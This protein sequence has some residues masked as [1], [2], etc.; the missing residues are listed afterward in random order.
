MSTKNIFVP[1]DVPEKSIDTFVKNYSALTHGTNNMLLFSADQKIEHLHKDFIGPDVDPADSYPTH[2]FDIASQADIGGMATQ[3]GLIARY[4]KQYKNINYVV[5]LNAKTNIIPTEYADPLSKELWTIQQVVQF[6]EQTK[7]PI[8]GIGYTVYLGS[9]F[10]AEM[11]TQAAQAVYEA[12]QHGLVTILWMYP[13]GECLEGYERQGLIIAGAAGVANAL[14]SD[15][16]KIN[17]PEPVDEE[18]EATSNQWL[19]IAGQAAGNTRLL[20]SGGESIAPKKFIAILK[21]QLAIEGV[22]GAAIGRN[23]H[24]KSL[25]DA[26]VFA[27]ELAAMIYK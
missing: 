6:K 21:E 12:H 23:I 18:D 4:G 27:K 2:L 3:L 15:F 16:A 26:V 17:A 22:G 24:Q 7:L 9:Q 25:K 19:A 20:I 14:G 8:C 11:L 10:E 1:A 5:K 13:R